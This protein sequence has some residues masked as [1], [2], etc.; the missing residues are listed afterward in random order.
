MSSSRQLGCS[1]VLCPAGSYHPEGAATMYSACRPCPPCM[2]NPTINAVI[3]RT[4]CD[5]DTGTFLFGDV[6]GDGVLSQREVLFVFFLNTMG[7]SWGSQ[8]QSWGDIDVHECILAGVT[9]VAG[10]VAKID[11]SDAT[12]CAKGQEPP[13]TTSSRPCLGIS[14]ELSFL[15]NLEVLQLH[16]QSNLIGTIPTQFGR[17]KKLRFLDISHCSLITGTIPT[18]VGRMTNLRQLVLQATGLRGTIPNELFRLISLEKLF[19]S[20]NALTGTLPTLIGR[21]ENLK[22]G[23]RSVLRVCPSVFTRLTTAALLSLLLPQELTVS[24]T[25][26]NGTIPTELGRLIKLEN[27]EMYGNYF[28]GHV[29]KELGS[30]TNLKRIG[31]YIF[32]TRWFVNTSMW[33]TSLTNQ[34]T[35]RRF[36]QQ[37]LDRNT[38]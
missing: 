14:P 24:R 26:L 27:L 17:L 15:P 18:Q 20:M 10:Q 23:R 37:W 12:L 38:A 1:A 34:F 16:K 9:C 8:F 35:C 5:S 6:N 7:P 28:V 29:P 33:S 2:S 21:L 32:G 25:Q 36:F 22:V 4:T 3:G 19:L 13:S 30:C 11:L 31:T